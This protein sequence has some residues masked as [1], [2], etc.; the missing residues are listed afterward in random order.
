MTALLLAAAMGVGPAC[1]S[2]T[3]APDTSAESAPASPVI[4]TGYAKVSVDRYLVIDGQDMPIDAYVPD[5]PAPWPVVVGFHG[6]SSAFKDAE[7]NTVIAE[8]A[9]AEG[10]LVFAPTWIAGDPFPLGVGDIVDLRQA[11][12][13]AVAFAQQWA[14]ELG[15]DPTDT[16]AYGFS[17]G[18]GPAL[19]SLVAPTG[20]VSGC[21]IDTAPV[22]VV[23]AVL[24]DGEYFFQSR[25]FDT[26][27]AEDLP[28][29]QE[30]VARLT[31]RDRWPSELDARVYVWAAESGTAPRAL[32]DPADPDWIDDRDPSGSIVSDLGRLGRLDD[33]IVD[34]VDG[35]H[36][37]ELRLGGA[38]ID[39]DLEIFPGGHSVNDKVDPLVAALRVVG[40]TG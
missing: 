10:M 22:P 8:R 36:F 24:G 40:A 38:G 33:G 26:A 14:V 4:S 32:N 31:E 17:A 21:E 12:S 18:A 27:F 11:A 19:A 9:A 37:I 1:T 6:H 15:G 28:A 13:C 3:E 30:E 7:S 2:A 16:V 20:A 39:V 35:A 25:P 5:R 23:G 34:Y 29:M